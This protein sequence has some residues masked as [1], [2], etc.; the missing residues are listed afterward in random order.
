MNLGR[1]PLTS[2]SAHAGVPQDE[3]IAAVLHVLLDNMMDG[4]DARP[5]SMMVMTAGQL[6]DGQDEC[7]SSLGRHVLTKAY[8]NKVDY[9]NVQG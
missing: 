7:E 2:T 5:A 6:M 3:D 8:T 4:V 9:C 1:P